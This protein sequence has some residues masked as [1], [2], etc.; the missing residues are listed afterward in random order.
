MGQREEFMRMSTPPRSAK[1]SLRDKAVSILRDEIL[2]FQYV[3]GEVLREETLGSLLGMSRTP[4]RSAL[5]QLIPDG[6]V[7]Y[8][9]GQ[10]FVVAQLGPRD[11]SEA[12]DVREALECFCVLNGPSSDISSKLDK[13]IVFF[14]FYKRNPCTPTS[15]EWNLLREADQLLHRELVAR[16]G[17]SL[18]LE[19]MDRLQVRLTYFRNIAWSVPTRFE[20]GVRDHLAICE[21]I[22]SGDT[23]RASELISAHLRSGRQF[24][25]DLMAKPIQRGV[26]IPAVSTANPFRVWLED[27]SKPP[28]SADLMIAEARM[29]RGELSD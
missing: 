16:S 7:K 25:L 28:D 12:Y 9:H 19:I 20:V 24:L 14:S 1:V 11:I 15:A 22:R 29:L 8:V 23:Q 10:G 4:I 17:N 3:P 26:D 21:C 5:E 27:R 2:S 18:A 13:F 6:L